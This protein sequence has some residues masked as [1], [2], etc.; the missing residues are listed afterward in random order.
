MEKKNFNIR[1]DRVELLAKTL[2]NIRV[3]QEDVFSFEVK[4]RSS[5]KKEERLIVTVVDV[6]I[7]KAAGS[8]TAASFTAACGFIVENFEDAFAKKGNSLLKELDDLFKTISISTMRGI[9]Y[10]ELRGTHLHDVHLPVF[11]PDSLQP[12]EQ[13]LIA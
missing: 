2:N 11:L 12:A 3:E 1:F 6:L 9:I 4:T 13:Q 8:K 5:I 7:K 10:S